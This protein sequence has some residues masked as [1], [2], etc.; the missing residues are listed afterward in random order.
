MI[1]GLPISEIAVDNFRLFPPEY[2]TTGR[3][4]Q[5]VRPSRFNKQSTIY[6]ILFWLY[7]E[8]NEYLRMKY[9]FV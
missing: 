4:D 7:R 3:S 5:S 8:T 1:D 2:W 6:K 9:S